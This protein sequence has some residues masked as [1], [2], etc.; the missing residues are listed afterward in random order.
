MVWGV[1]ALL[2]FLTVI[3]VLEKMRKALGYWVLFPVVVIPMFIAGLIAG[4]SSWW[5]NPEF[6]G[7]FIVSSFFVTLPVALYFQLKEEKP[8]SVELNAQEV[9]GEKLEI[10]TR[11]TKS[12]GMELFP[13]DLIFNEKKK[14]EENLKELAKKVENVIV[15][16]NLKKHIVGQDY[17]LTLIEYAIKGAVKELLSG[18]QKREKILSSF[19]LVGTTGVGKTETAKAVAKLLE[20][21]GYEFLRVDMNQ[22]RDEHSI[23]TLLGSPRGYLGSEKG[24]YLTNAFKENPKRVILFDEVEKAH[25]DVMSFLL[26]FLD[27]GYVIERESGKRYEPLLSIVFFTSN[28]SAKEIGEI[29]RNEPDEIERELK[30]RKILEGFFAPEFLGR[31]DEVVPYRPLSFEDLVEI[32]KRE[33]KKYGAEDRARELAE[34]YYSLANEYGVRF[35]LKKI[36]REVVRGEKGMELFD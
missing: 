2:Y 35:F 22:F 23:W 15:Y 11:A 30:I 8:P 21:L 36:V 28:F 13:D 5:S 12:E 26:Q 14:E 24:G 31:L 19:V 34:K 16:E 33:L 25:P 29:A 27:E 6:W 7:W 17:A 18:N 32:A 4:F 20:P 10:Y 1:L 3:F 9:Q